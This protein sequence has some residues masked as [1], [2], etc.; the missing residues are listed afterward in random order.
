MYTHFLQEMPYIRWALYWEVSYGGYCDFGPKN[1]VHCREVFA[2]KCLLHRGF[3]MR[4]WAS[5]HL[6]LRKK[7]AVERCPLQRMPGVRRFHCK[8]KKQSWLTKSLS[9][10]FQY[11]NWREGEI[12][13]W[14]F[15]F[16]I[17]L[18]FLFLVPVRV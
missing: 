17:K 8:L 6:F 13:E 12:T 1:D 5:F 16:S 7:F 3:V 4:V 11:C 15:S 2:I 10:F 14:Y 18:I 9:L